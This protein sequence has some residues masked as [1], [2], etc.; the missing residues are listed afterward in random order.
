M[1]LSRASENAGEN[2]DISFEAPF[3]LNLGGQIDMF[4]FRCFCL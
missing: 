2:D 3:T 4:F 1:A